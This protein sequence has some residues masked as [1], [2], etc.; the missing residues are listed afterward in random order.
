[1]G[2]VGAGGAGSRRG[3][4]GGFPYFQAVKQRAF[5]FPAGTRRGFPARRGGGGRSPSPAGR[6]LRAVGRCL[7]GKGGEGRRFAVSAV[8]FPRVDGNALF[9]RVTKPA[10]LSYLFLKEHKALFGF[11]VYIRLKK[12]YLFAKGLPYIIG[13]R[14]PP[15]I[16]FKAK[17]GD[18]PQQKT[19]G[20]EEKSPVHG[21]RF[22]K[23]NIDISAQIGIPDKAAGFFFRFFFFFPGFFPCF[24]F[25]SSA[26][27]VT[28]SLGALAFTLGLVYGVYFFLG[29]LLALSLL[30]G[31][32]E[33]HSFLL[34]GFLFSYLVHLGKQGLQVNW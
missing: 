25:L 4:R 28:D 14:P 11:F 16:R 26:V 27:S 5:L 12:T 13:V 20:K 17:K 9:R 7:R 15:D 2:A 29:K 30:K 24:T 1:L 21:A 19:A 31:L 8:K 23:G 22:L 10:K 18:K 32:L 3:R 33:G 34:R 6:G